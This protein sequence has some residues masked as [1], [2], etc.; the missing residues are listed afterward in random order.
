MRKALDA[1]RPI[2]VRVFDDDEQDAVNNQRGCNDQRSHEMLLHIFIESESD[3]ARRHAGDDDFFPKFDGFVFFR[4]RLPGGERIQPVKV[5][6]DDGQDGA[7]LDDD[8]KHIHEGFGNVQFDEF[9]HKYH[10]A[11]AAY[12]QPFGDSFYDSDDD[13]FD[14][15]RKIQ[16][17]IDSSN[18][19][20]ASL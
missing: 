4:S 6:H 19:F 14:E 16:V 10:V 5:Q 8:E 17:H 12:R 1:G 3:D 13:R 7:E 18:K 9:V 11:G 2:G 20:I 15:F